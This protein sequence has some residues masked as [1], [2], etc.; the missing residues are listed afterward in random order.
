[1]KKN[2]ITDFEW[3]VMEVL[4]ENSPLPSREIIEKVKESRPSWNDITIRTY[5]NRLVDKGFLKTEKEKFLVY[6]P[7]ISREEAVKKETDFFF[8]KVYKSSKALILSNFLKDDKLT[9]E[10]I[11]ILKQIISEKDNKNGK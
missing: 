7:Q 9:N 5:I 11:N 4:W 3:R 8:K 6:Y 2:K 1:M 10:E